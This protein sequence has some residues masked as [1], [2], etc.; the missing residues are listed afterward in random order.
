MKPSYYVIGVILGAVLGISLCLTYNDAHAGWYGEAGVGVGTGSSE[1]YK[2]AIH[3]GI[4]AD[5]IYTGT[6]RGGYKF[7]TS[8]DYAKFKIEPAYI[9]L[10]KPWEDENIITVNFVLCLG[11]C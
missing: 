8:T 10:D 5:V 9:R 1:A 11:D 6:V 3:V 7:D 4:N 2:D